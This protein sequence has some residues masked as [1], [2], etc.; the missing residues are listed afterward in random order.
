[1]KNEKFIMNKLIV[2]IVNGYPRSGKDEFCT[3]VGMYDSA[4]NISTVDRVKEA[5]QI[6]GWDGSKGPED[7]KMLSELKDFATKYFDGPYKEVTKLIKIYEDI[8][9]TI[10]AHIREPEEIE[11][12]VDFCEFNN[13]HCYKVLVSRKGKDKQLLTNHADKNVLDVDYDIMVN[14]NRTI[15]KLHELAEEIIYGIRTGIL[16]NIEKPY[17]T[18]HT[19]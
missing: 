11:R 1:M 2:L 3:G 4:I 13:I 16:D 8:P 14:N 6:L 5:A 10:C 12:I 17:I 7:R 18:G 19:E 15:R 9:V